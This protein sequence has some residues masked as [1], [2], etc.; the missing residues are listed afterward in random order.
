MT[1]GTSLKGV[2]VTQPP[3]IS[4][5]E[6]G[7]P[8]GEVAGEAKQVVKD[9]EFVQAPI[10]PIIPDPRATQTTVPKDPKLRQTPSPARI[11]IAEQAIELMVAKES[12]GDITSSIRTGRPYLAPFFS[13]YF[14]IYVIHLSYF[15]PF[16]RH[17]FPF[18]RPNQHPNCF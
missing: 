17:C 1:G 15:H 9:V 13:A 14:N 3:T 16:K 6:E 11:V 18:L 4:S 8:N 7:L 10:S 2:V 5:V 12:F